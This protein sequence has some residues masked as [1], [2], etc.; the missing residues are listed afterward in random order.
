MRARVV[1]AIGMI[2]S[3]G[4]GGKNP[5]TSPITDRDSRAF[6]SADS[7]Y[8]PP[9]D[10]RLFREGIDRVQFAVVAEGQQATTQMMLAELPAKELTE[11]ECIRLIGK[12]LQGEGVPVLLRA[13]VL[14]EE[15]GAF[16]VSTRGKDVLV[17]HDCLGRHPLPMKRKTVV[18]RLPGI[19]KK[20]FV[21]CG[22]DE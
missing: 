16:A 6:T 22:M 9:D 3:V 18:A 5:D 1:F 8:S 11:A 21:S 17:S 15:N 20:V 12:R 4:C 14:N 2:L 19:P 10:E 13:V 7:W